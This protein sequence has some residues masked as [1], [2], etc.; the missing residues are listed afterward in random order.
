MD[1]IRPLLV[2]AGALISFLGCALILGEASGEIDWRRSILTVCVVWGVL[3]WLITELLSLLGLLTFSGVAISWIIGLIFSVAVCVRMA[4]IQIRSLPRLLLEGLHFSNPFD[5]YLSKSLGVGLALILLVLSLVA[6]LAAPNTWDSQTY[7]LP[8][9]MHWQ[10]NQDVNFYP[11]HILRQLHSAPWAEM[12]I[13]HLHILAGSDRLA[14]FIQL[15]AMIA[16]LIGVSWIAKH[17]GGD[18]NVQLFSSLAAATLPM[19]ILQSTSTQNDYAAAFWLVCFVSFALDQSRSQT[20]TSY[21]LAGASLG[22]AILTKPTAWVFAASFAFWIGLRLL[23]KL[24]G[25][26]WKPAVTIASLVLLI[27]SGYFSRN[28]RL[29]G[30]PLGPLEEAASGVAFRYTN[31]VFTLRSLASNV[32]RNVGLQLSTPFEGVNDRLTGIIVRF[33]SLLGIDPSDPGS[34]WPGSTFSVGDW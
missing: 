32:L 25:D 6:L 26:V 5:S 17:L 14:N 3:I 9:I 20:F 12:A 33:H 13:L 31:D 7:H 2:L 1:S 21:L 27:N 4:R 18:R 34:T 29:Y 23:K 8:R 19:G 10:Q 11:T 22:L 28:V 15:F 16:A 30:N 24:K